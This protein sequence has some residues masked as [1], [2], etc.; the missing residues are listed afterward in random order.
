[1]ALYVYKTGDGSLYSWSPNDSDPVAPADVLAANG[2][3]VVS[4]LP[5]KDATHDWDATQKTVVSITTPPPTNF[6]DAH[7]FVMCFTGAESVAIKAST[8][9]Q[10]VRFMLMLSVAKRVDLNSATVQGGVNYLASIGLI[11]PARV[12]QILAGQEQAS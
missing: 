4:G 9:A 6:I 3:A 2:M 10:V 8:D 1:M 5:A 7:L 12:A 11:Q